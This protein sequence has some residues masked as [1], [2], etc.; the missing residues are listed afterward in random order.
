MQTY[1]FVQVDVFTRQA[2]GGNQLAVFPEAEQLSDVQMQAIAR[3]MNYSES[4]F[5]L[6]AANTAAAARVRIF[7]PARELPFAGHPVVGTGW[8]MGVERGRSRLAL[9]LNSGTLNVTI[10]P[11]DGWRGAAWM[12]Q[13]LPR[14]RPVDADRTALAQL[15]GLSVD[16]L[17]PNLPAELGSAGV[18]FLYLP[19]RSLDAVRRAQ[20]DAS[21]LLRFFGG[22]D[23]PAVYLFSLEAEAPTAAAHARMLSLL[24]G[25]EVREDPATGSAAGPLGVYLVRHG[26]REPGRLL[27]EQGYE[28]QRPSQVEVA[29]D[30]EDGRVTRVR[31][32]GGVVKVAEG[33]LFF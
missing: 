25:R 29:I 8:V 28:L 9:H 30:A 32:G 33:Q 19:L 22:H 31:V 27:V 21:A 2:F 5:I 14:F 6:P 3:E 7:T 12:E 23:H 11:G 15:V 16:D 24:L 13:P 10:E 18:E 4:T 17:D 20:A 1:R 26:V